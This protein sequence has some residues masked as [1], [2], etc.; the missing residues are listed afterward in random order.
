LKESKHVILSIANS[1][2]KDLLYGSGRFL[3]AEM[4]IASE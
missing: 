3:A 4:R 1:G 2:A